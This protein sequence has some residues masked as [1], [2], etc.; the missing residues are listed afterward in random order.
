MRSA[1]GSLPTFTSEF[2]AL[3]VGDACGDGDAEFA[4][5]HL[6]DVAMGGGCLLQRELE[7]G[8]EVLSAHSLLSSPR[9]CA[10]ELFEETG[11]SA[12]P[13]GEVGEGV[14]VLIAEASEGVLCPLSEAVCS[15]SE[16]AVEASVG[17]ASVGCLRCAALLLHLF[18]LSPVEAVVVVAAS[19]LGVG[20]HLVGLV[21]LL[22]LGLCRGVVGVKVGVILAG[23]FPVGPLDVGLCG[24]AL[25]AEDAVIVDVV[26]TVQSFVGDNGCPPLLV[27]CAGGVNNSRPVVLSRE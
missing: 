2:D 11:E 10:K 5:E 7:F 14:G 26:H 6:D 13:L 12:V 22:E 15:L 9:L 4:V 3:S 19:L 16:G 21:Q 8:F 18:G 23:Q 27:Q 17:I 20:Q 24:G 1:V 25:Y